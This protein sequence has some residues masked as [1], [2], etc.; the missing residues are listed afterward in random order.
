MLNNLQHYAQ[1]V[2]K[3]EL[4]KGEETRGKKNKFGCGNK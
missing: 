2:R 1:S 4:S 3:I